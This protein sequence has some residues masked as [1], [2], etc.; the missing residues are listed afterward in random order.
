[1]ES[2]EREDTDAIYVPSSTLPLRVPVTAV[3]DAGEG[4]GDV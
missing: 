2:R 1:M 4:A 3:G